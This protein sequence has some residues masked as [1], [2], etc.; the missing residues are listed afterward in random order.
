MPLSLKHL[1]LVRAVVSEGTLTD[2]AKL[3]YLTQS[4]LS[5]QL[6]DLEREAGAPVF[7]RVGRRM[8]PTAVGL[9]ILRTAEGTLASLDELT[10][11][12]ERMASGRMGTLRVTTQC[13]T[14]YY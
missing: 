10:E 8:L 1:R 2:A 5:H 7:V 6:N 4:A 9:R 3:L 12:L 13:Q 11:D 14:A